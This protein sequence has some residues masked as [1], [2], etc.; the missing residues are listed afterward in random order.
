MPNPVIDMTG[1]RVGS[2]TVVSRG[3]NSSHRQPRWLCQCDCGNTALVNGLRLRRALTRSCGCLRSRPPEHGMSRSPT[4]AS[5]AAMKGR[6]KDKSSR[7][8][9]ARGISVCERWEDFNNFLADMGERPAGHSIDR[10]DN[11]GNYE[12]GN[13][14]WATA[15]TQARNTRVAVM[16]TIDGETKPLIEWA[17]S[18]GISRAGLKSRIKSGWPVREAVFTKVHNNKENRTC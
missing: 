17:E 5:W 7:H 11:D 13:C 3:P 6:C 2:L 8:H 9:G 18:V 4:Y 10:I 14:R 12:P 16:L 15:T 1:F